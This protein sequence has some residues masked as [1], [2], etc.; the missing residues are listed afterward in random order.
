[1]NKIPGWVWIALVS[2]HLAVL[3]WVL[4]THGWEF[5]DSDRYEQ[6]AANIAQHGVLYAKPWLGSA[7][8]G[9][10]I[11]E[12][13]IRPPGYPLAVLALGRWATAPVLLLLAQN[14]L[15]LLNIGIVLNWWRKRFGPTKRQWA[16]AVLLVLTFPSQLIYASAVM[17]EI[18]LQTIVL[19]MVAMGLRFV[20]TGRGKYFLGAASAV[21]LA[22]LVK[23][24]FYPLAGVMAVGGVV[25]AWRTK[26]PWLAMIGTVP[27]LVALAYMTRNLE[28][29]GY[30]HFS[31]ISTINLLHYNAAGV[32]RQLEG[33]NAEK[34]WVTAVLRRADAQPSFAGRQAVL[35][36]QASA[37]L[38]AHPVVYARQQALGMAALLLD[39][40]RYD[41]AK[42]LQLPAPP[43]GGLLAQSRSGGLW[44]ALA[45]LPLGLLALLALIGLANATRLL[46][47]VRGLL[48]LAAAD[49]KTRI[50]CWLTAGLVLYVALLTGPLGATRFLVPVWPLLLALALAGMSKRRT[51]QRPLRS[52]GLARA[53]RPVPTTLGAAG[54]NR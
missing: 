3:G 41:V 19:G 37:V 23:P 16:G 47:A 40:G 38:W 39:P 36:A 2:A 32:V 20:D 18:V 49:E 22:L 25:V 14:L 52:G 6:A 53:S 50:G 29:T 15:S 9:K 34:T 35:N 45:S 43:G 5:T 54:P 24:V 30:F 12:F 48:V 31:S 21:A 4:A 33:A 7:P 1:M 46:L 10:D 42:I 51:H 44:R 27:L 11:Q 28:R 13:T 17:S 26:T 8:T